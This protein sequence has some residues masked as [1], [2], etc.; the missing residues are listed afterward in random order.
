MSALS[1]NGENFL[2]L[3]VWKKPTSLKVPDVGGPEN[4]V[5]RP[6]NISVPLSGE[7]SALC[8]HQNGLIDIDDDATDADKVDEPFFLGLSSVLNVEKQSTD[9]QFAKSNGV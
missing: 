6:G 7:R 5:T 3:S 9:G 8:Q 4:V 1:S 2:C